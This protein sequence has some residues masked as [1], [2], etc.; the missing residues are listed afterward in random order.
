MI[1]KY[2]DFIGVYENV[3]EEGY[4]EHLISE[5]QRLETCSA[6]W[7]REGEGAGSHE[8]DDYS[9]ALNS[10]YFYNFKERGAGDVFWEG[11]STCYN[12]Y[13]SHY[14]ILKGDDLN[15]LCTWAKLQ[16]TSQGGGYHFWHSEL[17]TSVQHRD[18]YLVYIVYLNSLNPEDGGETEFLYQ[19]KRFLP[20]KNTA[21]LFPAT[22][23]H[24][25]KGNL[26]LSNV[27]KYIVTGWFN[28]R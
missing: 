17:G 15:L 3:F 19:R 6:G 24:T 13:K 16:R 4:C 11:L 2:E 21:I 1:E 27:N 8:K 10:N 12:R 5:F 23:T 26:V 9:M 14:S 20:I 28:L 25:H 22:F 18:R 7:T